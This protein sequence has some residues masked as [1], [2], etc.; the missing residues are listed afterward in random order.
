MCLVPLALFVSCF[1]ELNSSLR[2]RE[3][4]GTLFSRGVNFVS[5]DA[6]SVDFSECSGVFFS[7]VLSLESLLSKRPDFTLR[8]F[9]KRL[10][11][12]GKVCSSVVCVRDCSCAETT[13]NNRL[14]CMRQRKLTP[15][16]KRV[17]PP[18]LLFFP[19]TTLSYT[20]NCCNW[21]LQTWTS[22]QQEWISNKNFHC[23]ESFFP[24]SDASFDTDWTTGWFFIID[25]D[26]HATPTSF[27]RR[28]G[29]SFRKSSFI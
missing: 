20:C 11:Q 21:V 4:G 18:S 15:R 3:G 14:N 22:K 16:E 17:T 29:K 19:A 25:G 7:S 9:F 1:S 12:E 23:L 2:I 10:L 24:V 8:L 27:G 28:M 6:C 5:F 26:R 13:L